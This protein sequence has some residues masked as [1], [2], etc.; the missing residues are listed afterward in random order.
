MTSY[1]SDVPEYV[2]PLTADTIGREEK[3]AAIAVLEGGR[4]TMG[5]RVKRFEK[6]FADYTGAKHCVMVN[7]GSSANLLLAASLINGINRKTS[8]EPGDEVL[9]PA[10]LWPTTLWPIY[11]LGLKPVLVDVCPETM[12]IDVEEARKKITAKTRAI[13][14]IHVLGIPADMQKITAF[15]EEH[16]L[17]VLEDCCE[18][19]GARFRGQHVGTFGFGGSFSFFFSHHISTMEGGAIITNDDRHADDLRSMRAHGWIRDRSD[20]AEIIAN[21]EDKNIDE[22]WCF[23]LPGF[24]LRPTELQG[25][26]GTV[27]L[28][29][30]DKY[31]ESRRDCLAVVADGIKQFPW[32]QIVGLNL[33]TEHSTSWMNIP[34]LIDGSAPKDKIQVTDIFERHGIETRPIIAGDFSKQPAGKFVAQNGTFPVTRALHERGLMMSAMVDDLALLRSA[35]NNVSD[36]IG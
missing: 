25:A 10:L 7:S 14:L 29:K 17:H 12:S 19:L 18:S 32:F 3:D 2:V 36:E 22:R 11:Q 4:Y 21:L 30:L 16:N 24:N 9:V 35:M 31:L 28:G 27:Q 33:P 15:A 26:I 23:V 20:K 1:R 13:F 34:L 6:L 5:D 8:V